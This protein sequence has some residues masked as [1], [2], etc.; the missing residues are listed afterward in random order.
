M[1]PDFFEIVRESNNHSSFL[2]FEGVV[3][4]MKQTYELG[5]KH[6]QE[7]FLDWLSEMNHL[8]DNINYI[9]EEWKNRNQL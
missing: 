4:A 9:I 6:G 2:N 8:S 7:E 5:K 3:E 1:K